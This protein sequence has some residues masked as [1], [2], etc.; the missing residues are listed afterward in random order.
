MRLTREFRCFP[1]N[2]RGDHARLNSWSGSPTQGLLGPYWTVRA[3]VEGPLDAETGFVCNTGDLDA[4]LQRTMVGLAQA[5]LDPLR[6][7]AAQLAGVLPRLFGELQSRLP[8]RLALIRL[9]LGL[10]P[11][12]SL[13]VDVET[14]GMEPTLQRTP[15]SSVTLESDPSRGVH[16][17]V[18]MVVQLTQSF[19][20]SASH[21]LY[22]PDRGDAE[23]RK[24]FGKCANANGHG[25]NYVVDVT[26]AGAPREG[27][28]T[29]VDLDFLQSAVKERVIDR[30]DHRHLNLD[31]AEFH[32]LNPSVE[33]IA[34]VIWDLLAPAFVECRL[35]R[36]RV[37]ETPKTCAEYSGT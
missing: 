23:N 7:S 33:N 24:L 19:E 10:N 27:S 5:G 28:G 1:A 22:C 13:A 17:E 15:T 11:H 6:A 37:W 3:T 34:R 25:H 20:F 16:W 9:E 21:R 30:F 35:A 12:F 18:G 8:R 31:C 36:V 29:V 26:V 2:L 14:G 32:T 4:L